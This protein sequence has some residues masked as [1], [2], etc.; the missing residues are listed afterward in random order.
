MAKIGTSIRSRSPPVSSLTYISLYFEVLYS[1]INGDLELGF[2]QSV[3]VIVFGTCS[4]T[5]TM[6]MEKDADGFYTGGKPHY[7][8]TASETYW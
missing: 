3:I 8:Q 4:L 5:L 2:E 6:P 1:V 7:I